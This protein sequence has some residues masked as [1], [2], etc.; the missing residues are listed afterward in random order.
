MSSKDSAKV[1]TAT[2][3]GQGRAEQGGARPPGKYLVPRIHLS[4]LANYST[5]AFY[6]WLSDSVVAAPIS[7]SALRVNH[8]Q[9]QPACQSSATSISHLF[10]E[11][12]LICR[13]PQPPTSSS[14][15]Y[16]PNM[17]S[18]CLRRVQKELGDIAKDTESQIFAEPGSAHDLT[19]LRAT[20]PG[21]RDTPYEGGTFI[22]DVAIPNEYPFKPPVMKFI[23]KLWHPNVSSQTVSPSW[24]ATEYKLICTGSY[25]FRHFG[26][27]LV[28]STHYQSRP[29]IPPVPPQHTRTKRSTGCRSSKHVN[30]QPSTV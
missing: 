27:G 2:T 16:T 21:P 24:G 13:L 14:K 1:E 10:E 25:L 7:F 22:V 9:H 28:A 11:A 8:I 20:F 3:L 26:F 29:L 15:Q 17:T 18:N 30:E 5:S 19:H 12:S 6:N 4:S 23:T